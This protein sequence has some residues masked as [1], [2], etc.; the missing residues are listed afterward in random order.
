MTDPNEDQ[1]LANIK[2]SIADMQNQMQSTYQNLADIKV[3]AKSHD[4]LVEIVLTAT[5][6]FED[7]QFDNRA[8]QGGVTEFKKRIREAFTNVVKKVQEA[9][10]AKTLELLQQMKIPDEIRNL[11]SPSDQKGDDDKGGG[12]NG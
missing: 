8:L 2:N 11:S 1:L 3:S 7:I 12:S 4:D 6:A 5:Y 9:T 10:Q